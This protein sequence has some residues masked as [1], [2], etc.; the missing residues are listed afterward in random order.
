MM[1]QKYKSKSIEKP[2][3]R[4]HAMNCSTNSPD[5]IFENLQVVCCCQRHEIFYVIVGL[6]KS[7]RISS[8]SAQTLTSP[9]SRA[10]SKIHIYIYIYIYIGSEVSDR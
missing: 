3:R 8:L 4:K 10:I 7:V 6:I 1:S 5:L 9:A 2:N